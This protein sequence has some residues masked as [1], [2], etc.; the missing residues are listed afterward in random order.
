MTISI[1]Q[2]EKAIAAADAAI[3]NT[4]SQY[5]RSHNTLVSRDALA[6]LR[7]IA[8]TVLDQAAKRKRRKLN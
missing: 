2:V 8:Q 6:T 7:T 5:S 3:E 4:D 1:E